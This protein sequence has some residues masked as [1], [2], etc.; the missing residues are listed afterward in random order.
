[1]IG[2][3]A[4]MKG[5]VGL[6]ARC[7]SRGSR[8]WGLNHEVAQ[9]WWYIFDIGLVS[10]MWDKFLQFNKKIDTAPPQMVKMHE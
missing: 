10:R 7:S 3:E 2:R 5:H 8:A 1:M 6:A 4:V 9:E